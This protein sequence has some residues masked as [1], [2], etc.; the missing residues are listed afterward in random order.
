SQGGEY[1]VVVLPLHRN[2][3]AALL[4]RM[5]LY[6]AITRAR[7]LLLVV[8]S[9]EALS[10]AVARGQGGRRQTGLAQRMAR[11]AAQ[12]GLPSAEARVFRDE[13]W[14]AGGGAPGAAAARGGGGSGAAWGAVDGLDELAR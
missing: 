9:A 2:F 6:T 5:L 12:E 11:A 13:G 3:G 8:G 7:R 1:P 10:Q 14:E 4:S